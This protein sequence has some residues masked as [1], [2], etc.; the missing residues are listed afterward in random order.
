MNLFGLFGGDKKPEEQGSLG[1]GTGCDN[2]KMAGVI[3]CPVFLGGAALLLL[4]LIII[5]I[6]IIIVIII[7]VIINRSHLPPFG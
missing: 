4:L 1:M 3:D 6:I 2:C 7:I 5:I